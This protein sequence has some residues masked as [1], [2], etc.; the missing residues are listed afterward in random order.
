MIR[1]ATI[2]LGIIMV[3]DFS[4]IDTV[5]QYRDFLLACLTALVIQPWMARQLS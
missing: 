1:L 5:S 4:S 3:F 2:A